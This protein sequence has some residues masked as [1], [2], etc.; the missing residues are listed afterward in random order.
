MSI[1]EPFIRRP[2]ATSLLMLGV[3]VFGIS[4]Y[5]LLPIAALPNVDFP[6][7]TVTANYP[8]ASPGTMA[9]AIA[10]PLEQQFTA[11]PSLAQM[12]SLS[13]TGTTTITLVFDL[14][15]NIDG[16]AQDVL[17][18]IN[19]ASGLLPKDLP[20]PP[21]Y[22]KVNPANS[23]VLIYAVF[24]DALP[25]Y[26]L[27]DYAYTILAQQLSTVPGVSQVSVFGQKEYA[28]RV[29]INPG[30]LAAHGVGLEDV[31]NALVA[32]TVNGPKGSIEGGS[33]VIALDT[34]DQLLNASQ[35]G[36]VIVAYR[37]GAPMR[38]KDVGEA[39]DSIQNLYVGAWFN[40]RPAEG[41]AIRRESGA[42]TIELVNRIKELMPHLEESIPPSVHV[43]LMSD[44][45]L[46]TEAA[47]HDV[48]I[49]MII[50]IALVVLVI[51]IFLR[52]M[53]ATIIPSM[54]VPLSL[55]A[56]AGTMFIAG[57]SLDNISLMALTISVGFVVDD[58]IVMIE[59]IVRYIEQGERPLQ[60]ALRGAGQIGFTIISITF[61]LIAV[62]IPLFFMGGIIGRLFREFAVTVSVAV[63][64]S[65]VVS[66]T[67]TPVLCALFLKHQNA[68]EVGR[69]S[70]LA[71][72]F[73]VWLVGRY[74]RGLR[75]VFRHQFATL[76]TTLTLIVVTGALYTIIPKGFFPQQ[77]TGFIFGEVDMREDASF[78]LTADATQQIVDIVKADPAVAGVL[79]MAGAY[80]Y[81]P[82]ENTARVYIQ[83]KPFDERDVTADQVIGR[84]R[85]RV[86]GVQGAKFFM[87][88][89]QDITIGG[90]L[91]R[92][93]YQYT[94]TDSNVEELNHWAPI[95][96]EGMHK[97]P[98]LQDVTSDQ[99]IA[100]PHIAIDVDRSAASRLGLSASV[101]DQT[102]YD[103]F[104]QRQIATI[105]TATT[106][107]K[108][109]LEVAPQFRED[110]A[111]LSKIYV[112][113]PTGAQVPLSAFAHFASK[114]EPLSE[115]HQGQFPAITLSFN[116]APGK[117][118]G[119]AVD[120]IQA[121]TAQLRIPPTVNGSFQGTAQ[122]FQASLSS[123][124]LLVAAA[125]L[126][127]YIVLGILYE[128]Y[129]HPITILS[130]LPSAGVGALVM[131][132]LCGYD[133]SVIAI[134]G[135]ILLIGIVK[136]NAIMMIDFAL[137]AE[138]L[139]G[140]EPRE[141]IH[142][143]CLLR[144]RPIMMT[145]FAA[146][147]GSLP[148]ALGHGA[149]S[150]LRRPLGIAIIGGLLVSQWL[151]LYTTPVIYLYLERL[152]RWLGR[153]HRSSRVADAL[154]DVP[155]AEM[156]QDQH[157]AE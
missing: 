39:V 41:I 100:A 118:L 85:Q 119:Q 36:N 83:L 70:R 5:T 138:R 81:N 75:F 131:L 50:T 96:E 87:Q 112:Q 129:I 104:G 8:G 73:F 18:A 14:S 11:I 155:Q 2:I 21:T 24:S 99:Q 149:G 47:V 150:E 59:N 152:S 97:L 7:I 65:A 40:N 26:R 64:A 141:A 124:P 142:E 145:T 34:N 108:V 19:A 90:R 29:E 117:A 136:K 27:D 16:A 20:N 144:F 30:A 38:V 25:V 28:A 78:Q 89:G 147:F 101:I 37:N 143:A 57:F 44:R 79:S 67:L 140:K 125:I 9:S 111:T 154:S 69:L 32:A 88:A 6:T 157:G 80:A 72:Q 82:T 132:M 17:T 35:Y 127:V 55:L 113:S 122:A 42:N 71:E 92:T 151:T 110:P 52:T 153:S 86:A 105:Y 98:E 116:L 120:R 61:S 13:G 107:Y 103:A 126:V 60:A 62:F 43:V 33:K 58:A 130:A 4:A 77:D 31:R 54:A 91:S 45:S 22:K 12:T 156:A 66:L 74:D 106:Q 49:T 15:R 102:L 51:F 76:L 114:V 1:S 148:I 10:T 56:T 137:Q 133:L 63:V 121:L 53:W 115:S 93:Q 139:H 48:Q 146:L 84:L 68:N 134:I 94:L 128:S 3:L 46:V 95:L 23:P 135:I 123:M 109:V